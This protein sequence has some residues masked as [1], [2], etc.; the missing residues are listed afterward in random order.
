M[1][2]RTCRPP[3]PNLRRLSD[4]TGFRIQ[5][6]HNPSRTEEV[7]NPEDDVPDFGEYSVILPPEP[8]SFGVSHIRPRQVPDHILKPLY[9]DITRKKRTKPHRV[10]LGT[11]S[12]AHVREAGKLAKKVRGYAKSL[13]QAI[14]DLVHRSSEEHTYS[15]NTQLTGH[16][17]GTDFHKQPWI[18]HDTNEEPGIMVPGDCFTIE[19][20]IIQGSNP[21]G[22]IFPDGWTM[23]TENCARSA[24]AEHMVPIT[25]TGADVLT[26]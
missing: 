25:E 7:P 24:Q 10:V 17:I 19:P 18:V 20:S 8:F 16:G 2:L 13:V 6:Y 5:P 12:E 11:E 1:V 21:R 3:V 15:I 9:A 22:W 26:S 4:L 14:H 23:S